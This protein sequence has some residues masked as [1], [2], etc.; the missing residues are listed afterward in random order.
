MS[1]DRLADPSATLSKLPRL[2]ILGVLRSLLLL[3][4]RGDMD[5]ERWAKRSK[6]GDDC[7][8]VDTSALTT[9]CGSMASWRPSIS[10]R[11]KSALECPMKTVFPIRAARPLEDF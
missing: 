9:N 10:V 11:M 4:L 2:C 7:D 5:D 3:L 1:I 6:I 8:A